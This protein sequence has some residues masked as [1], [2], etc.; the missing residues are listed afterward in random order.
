MTLRNLSTDIIA[1]DGGNTQ[2]LTI[3]PSEVSAAGTY[4]IS[5]RLTGIHRG[6]YVVNVTIPWDD[7]GIPAR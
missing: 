7:P 6:D 2:T 4:A 5:R 3:A 1:M